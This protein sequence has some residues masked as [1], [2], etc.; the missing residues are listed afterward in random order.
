MYILSPIIY[1][2]VL[3]M[4]LIGRMRN[5]NVFTYDSNYVTDDAHGSDTHFTFP[6]SLI[7]SVSGR[8]HSA[9]D[10]LYMYILSL[11]LCN[12]LSVSKRHNVLLR[13]S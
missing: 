12:I 8:W 1:F 2:G 13:V 6:P 3:L 9:S 11:F 7:F 5:I 10:G 4:A